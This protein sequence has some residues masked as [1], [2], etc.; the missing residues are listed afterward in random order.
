MSAPRRSGEIGIN[1]EELFR[2]AG[3]LTSTLDL[4]SR[5]LSRSSHLNELGIGFVA[6]CF[7]DAGAACL[8][9]RAK[10]GNGEALRLSLNGRYA[11]ESCVAGGWLLVPDHVGRPAY[12]VPQPPTIRTLDADGHILTHAAG[13]VLSINVD[14]DAL[15]VEFW[16][17]CEGSLDLVVWRIDS[18]AHPVVDELRGLRAIEKQPAFLWS[19]HT[20]YTRPADVYGHLVF[21]HVYENHEVWPKYWRVCSELDAQALYVILSGLEKVT[22]KALYRLLKEQLVLSVVDRQRED[23]GWYHGEWTD[24]MES[25]YRLHCGA[26][27]MLTAALEEKQDERIRKAL[28]KAV[29]FIS[30]RAQRIDAGVWF[31]HDSLEADEQSIKR[32]PFR[33]AKSR[34]LGKSPSNM[35]ILNTHLDTIIALDRYREVTGDDRHV[36]QVASA[37]DAA[38]AILAQRPAEGIYRALFWILDL[39]LLPKTEAVR[40]PL[41]MRALKRIGWK[42][43]IPHLHRIKAIWPR[44]VMPNGFIDR[45]LTQEG[46]ATRYQSVHVWDLVRFLRRFQSDLGTKLLCQTL[47]YTQKESGIRQHWKEDP[48]RSDALG[49]WQE[50]LYWLCLSKSEANLIAWLGE[51]VIDS[52]DV[53]V[54]MA[55][56]LLG[57]NAEIVPP[58][59]PIRFRLPDDSRLRFVNLSHAAAAEF[60]FVNPTPEAIELKPDESWSSTVS[61]HSSNPSA[62]GVDLV[63]PGRGWLWA[64]KTDR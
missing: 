24:L 16:L 48:T 62:H 3:Q 12:W 7:H 41:V 45:S 32:Y 63:V 55:P 42:Y 59:E 29:T 2:V 4:P 21:G 53:N 56:S 8:F 10:A 40:L 57:G 64:R 30:G 54:G 44:I 52:E 14:V 20:Q 18:A 50:A 27:H 11:L 15:S 38:Q 37:C 39:T 13:D 25:H 26:I 5:R 23:G 22:G 61:W 58:A 43:L 17:A 6:D 36:S 51:A 46:F 47:A 34:A 60:L 1:P 33:W 35:L 9:L 31:M 28:D 49:F 19:S